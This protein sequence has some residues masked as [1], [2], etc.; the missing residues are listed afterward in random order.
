MTGYIFAG[1]SI[2]FIVLTV[3]S[4]KQGW[5]NGIGRGLLTGLTVCLI[6]VSG[7]SFYRVAKRVENDKEN[8]YLA[9][10]FVEDR[11]SDAALIHFNQVT[12]ANK[13]VSFLHSAGEILLEGMRDNDTMAGL[14]LRILKETGTY[15]E[16][17]SDLLGYFEKNEL[18]E[19]MVLQ[20]AVK[21]MC[22]MLKLK[23]EK[24]NKYSAY[25][26]IEAGS[27]N[28]YNV[29]DLLYQ[30]R[31]NYGEDSTDV[32]ELNN[33]L[34]GGNTWQA[35]QT[36]CQMVED[37]PSK[38][39]R[40][41]LAEVI[42]EMTYNGDNIPDEAFSGEL[43][44]QTQKERE[45]LQAS[46]DKTYEQMR[47]VQLKLEMATNEKKIEKL[48]EEKQALY[49]KCEELKD[50]IQNIYVYRAL[51]SVVDITDLEARIVEARLY[52]SLGKYDEA[53]NV[54]VSAADSLAAI[55]SDNATLTDGLKLVKK[56]YG[57]NKGSL[58]SA[59]KEFSDAVGNVLNINSQGM[60]AVSFSGLSRD[61]T[62]KIVS[63]L[64]Y[65]DNGI[66]VLGFDDSNYPEIKVT[67]GAREDIIKDVI[68]QKQIVV[69]DTRHQV[70][71][72]A[73]VDESVETS[74]CFVVDT[75][76][77]MAGDPIANVRTAIGS[78]VR[79][80]EADRELSL[81]TFESDASIRVPI[82]TDK[83]AVQMVVNMLSEGGGTNIDAGI[84]AGV[85][86]LESAT[87]L[88]T[89]M[90]LTDGQ[91]DVNMQIVEDAK[92]AGVTIYTIGFGSVNDALLK[93]IAEETGG[94]YIRAESSSE[95]SSVYNSLGNVI[96]NTVTVT[97]TVEENAQIEPRYFFL[98]S[99]NYGCSI[100][101]RYREETV[102][103][104]EMEDEIVVERI[105]S[106]L[107]S[108]GDLSS[109]IERGESYPI[110]LTGKNL[111][112]VVAA[113][114][115][116][117]DCML[118]LRNENEL[119]VMLP[120]F[121]MEGTYDLI[122]TDAAGESITLAEAICIYKDGEIIYY[123]DYR[124]GSMHF[125]ANE[126]VYLSSGRL[127]LSGYV[128]M[129]GVKESDTFYGYT[130]QLVYVN[131]DPAYDPWSS[132]DQD[133][134]IIDLGDSGTFTMEGTIYLG[135]NDP[136][137]G[138]SGNVVMASGRLEG[139]CE[140]DQTYISPVQD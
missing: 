30:Y 97:Y 78:F 4:F 95:L 57:E 106:Q 83:S 26:E 61:F 92:K 117:V 110:Y 81:V 32:L 53:I 96:G 136:A 38:D 6:G 55:F 28:G 122:L 131:Y 17:Q 84:Q 132:G 19:E 56:A 7:F 77:S 35:I 65:E 90:M 91:S 8:L 137:S 70:K 45:K 109:Y 49:D 121:I 72:S 125:E 85:K 116:D 1:L 10:R 79:D 33:D 69:K 94:R 103:N 135:Y 23:P 9:F 133:V 100:H 50:R 104:W 60:M 68:D 73:T 102:E 129:S 29:S 44:V 86:A 22:D 13:T 51:N 93:E 71:Y 21:L 75:S 123:Q 98:R 18:S 88:K 36:V 59:S 140:A 128:S 3:F 108:M 31:E 76:G 134:D 120:K 34:A 11:Q 54:L 80:M 20:N 82:T 14:K 66:Y 40:L 87:G 12:D 119:Y 46:Y 118:D 64:K 43:A 111:E 42:A 107:V 39:N 47:D 37:E 52:Y 2:I 74:L 138:N 58:S 48:T 67:L 24:E 105:S 63:D 114:I 127:L 99:E 89:M 130:E 139:V 115:G 16:E 15:D 126:T 27:V 112:K 41:L 25:Y 62:Q 113:K 124:L 5:M 101:Y